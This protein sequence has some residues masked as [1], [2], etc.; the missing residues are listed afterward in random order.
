[1][2]ELA[3]ADRDDM[4]GDLAALVAAV[5][6]GDLAAARARG[7]DLTS[8]LGT[9]GGDAGA[10][11]AALRRALQFDPVGLAE[12]SKMTGETIQNLNYLMNVPEAP[13]PAARLARM[14]VWRRGDVV[15]FFESMGRPVSW[16]D[17]PGPPS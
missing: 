1:M 9:A 3:V 7:G 13:A 12:I 8:R 4:I 5:L 15:R 11:E 16:T 17:T 2:R 6:A 10:V 14:K